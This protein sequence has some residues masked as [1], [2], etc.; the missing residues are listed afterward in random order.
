MMT[1]LLAFAAASLLLIGAPDASALT[2]TV[3]CGRGTHAVVRHALVRGRR[4]ARVSCI[5]TTRRPIVRRGAHR[6]W[7]RSA[8]VIGGAT[9]A[10]AGAGA[11]VGG[12]SGAL[13]G[14]A[15]DGAAG[16]GYEVAKRKQKRRR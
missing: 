12:K 9:A 1:R 5:A 13:V 16:T 4:V 8:A 7:K 14:A 10:G 6:S 15:V 2:R 3:R 11:L